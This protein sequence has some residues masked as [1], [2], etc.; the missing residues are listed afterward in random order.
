MLTAQKTS[1]F[2]REYE[3]EID[4]RV[5][6]TFRPSWWRSGGTFVVEGHEYTVRQNFWGVTYGMA[7][8]DG[9][10]VASADRVGRKRWTVDA[11]GRTHHFRRAS[12]W[13]GEQAMV[14]GEREIGSIRKL[15]MFRSG[16]V[17]DLPALDPALQVFVVAVVLTMWDNQAS[18]AASAGGG[19]S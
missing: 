17:A 11:E 19:G 16:A 10:V 6:T 1:A 14:D 2:K 4:G 3:I 5:V 9:T 12:M 18:A 7:M 8:A 13:T 15:G